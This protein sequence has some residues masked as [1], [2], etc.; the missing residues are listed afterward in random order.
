MPNRILGALPLGPLERF[1]DFMVMPAASI[2]RPKPNT[3]RL[4]AKSDG[5]HV[6]ASDGTDV[7]PLGTSGERDYTEITAPVSITATTEAGG[8]TIVTG[9]AV[10]YNGTDKIM[11]EFSAPYATP[12]ATANGHWIRFLL[13]DNGSTIGYFGFAGLN[14][15]PGTYG[16]V[17]LARRLTPS[18]AAHTYSVRAMVDA[19]TASVGAGAGGAAA[20]PPAFIRITKV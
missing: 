11:I 3:Y 18:N 17:R 8:N 9:A 2:L 14:G 15:D 4:V 19:G 5:M 12:D 6:I 13:F 10:T 1:R 16:P 20:Y 7:G